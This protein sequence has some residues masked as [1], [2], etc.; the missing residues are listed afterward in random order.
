MSEL[1]SEETIEQRAKYL[2]HKLLK[3]N[4]AGLSTPECRRE[5][6]EFLTNM[7]AGKDTYMRVVQ[8]FKTK[9]RK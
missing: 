2:G 6:R 4:R 1:L 8:Y 5:L 7:A 3:E 9:W